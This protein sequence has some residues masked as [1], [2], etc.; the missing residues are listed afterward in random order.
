MDSQSWITHMRLCKGY[1][2]YPDTELAF[3]IHC[4][5]AL[6]YAAVKQTNKQ[7]RIHI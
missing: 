3:F 6:Q 1:P 2:R 5:L 7:K 4:Q